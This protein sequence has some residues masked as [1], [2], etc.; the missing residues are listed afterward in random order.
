[1]YSESEGPIQFEAVAL[2]GD[3]IRLLKN[4]DFQDIRDVSTVLELQ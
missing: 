3:T 1:M 4:L 2:E